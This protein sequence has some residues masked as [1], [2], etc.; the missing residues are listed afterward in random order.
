MH[1]VLVFLSFSVTFH[2]VTAV[3]GEDYLPPAP[4]VVGTFPPGV[5]TQFIGVFVVDDRLVEGEESF[6]VSLQLQDPSQQD[7]E[8]GP[9]ATV[10]IIIEDD[11]ELQPM[12]K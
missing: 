7:A 12:S 1:L 10:T 11:D 5:A 3:S 4:S 2:D 6:T 8:L 9:R